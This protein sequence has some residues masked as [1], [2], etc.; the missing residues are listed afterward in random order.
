M[1]VNMFDTVFNRVTWDCHADGGSLASSLDDYRATLCPMF[2]LAYTAL[3]EDF[4]QRG[5]LRKH[6]SRCDG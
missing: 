2:D 1:T 5:L 3:L 4:E 6:P